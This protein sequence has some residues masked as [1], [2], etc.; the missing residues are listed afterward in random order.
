ME[1]RIVRWWLLRAGRLEHPVQLGGFYLI[2]AVMRLIGTYCA[3]FYGSK[4]RGLCLARRLCCCSKG[5]SHRVAYRVIVPVAHRSTVFRGLMLIFHA[6]EVIGRCGPLS[7]ELLQAPPGP[8]R[9]M[10]PSRQLSRRV[11]ISDPPWAAPVLS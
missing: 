3:G 10:P 6:S 9:R 1:L 7:L 5:V 2:A 8:C 11:E 4:D